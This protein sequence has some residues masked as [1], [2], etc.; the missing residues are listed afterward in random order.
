MTPGDRV[1]QL[2]PQALGTHFSRLLRHAW[3]TVGL[4]FNP[5]HHTGTVNITPHWYHWDDQGTKNGI[6][7][8][9]AKDGRGKF[10]QNLI[11]ESEGKRIPSVSCEDRRI[12]LKLFLN[13]LDTE[14]EKVWMKWL[15][16]PNTVT[17]FHFHEVLGGF[18][19]SQVI[20]VSL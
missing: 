8:G 2:Y 18:L 7:S 15:G 9:S 16:I 19:M 1:A 3:V 6:C 11:R 14:C 4:F 20:I 12:I 5:G 17:S 10:I 13:K